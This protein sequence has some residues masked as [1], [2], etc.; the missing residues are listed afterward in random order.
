MQTTDLSA[1]PKIGKISTFSASSPSLIELQSI[2]SGCRYRVLFMA[3]VPKMSSEKEAVKKK[4]YKCFL[5]NKTRK[6]FLRVLKAFILLHV[7][8]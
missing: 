7:N 8:S 5:T 2:A 1:N 3:F 4:S 6:R